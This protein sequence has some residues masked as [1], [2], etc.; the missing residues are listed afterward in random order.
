MRIMRS[1]VAS[2]SPP[3]SIGPTLSPC[4]PPLATASPASACGYSACTSSGVSS[5][6]FA[7]TS[8]ATHEAAEPPSPDPRGMPFV[9]FDLESERQFQRRPQR[10]QCRTGGVAFGLQRQVGHRAAYR[11]D[12]NGWFID[13]AHGGDVADAGDAVADD[14]EANADIAD[15]AWREGASDHSVFGI[16]KRA[17][18]LDARRSKSENTP[19]AVT[20]GPA[21]GP[22]TTSG[23]SR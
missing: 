19:A 16:H 11:C 1:A 7:A 12:A 22:C 23:L 15:R 17:P 8:A 13:A 5:K 2:T 3:S 4:R 6:A 20:S 14:V 21:P 18:R 9:E 10:D